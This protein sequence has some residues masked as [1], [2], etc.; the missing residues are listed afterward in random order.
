MPSSIDGYV[1]PSQ[2]H[3]ITHTQTAITS[4]QKCPAYVI[5]LI[6]GIFQFVDFFKRQKLTLAFRLP[7]LLVVAQQFP[8]VIFYI[9]LLT[10][11]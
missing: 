2:S 11:S 5:L 3:D 1:T 4:E 10:C 9:A 7:Y 6:W 8:R